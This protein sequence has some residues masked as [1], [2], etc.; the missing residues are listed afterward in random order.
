[1]KVINLFK[2]KTFWGVLLL[3][4][5][6][7]LTEFRTAIEDYDLSLDDILAISIAVIGLALSLL[8]RMDAHGKIAYTPEGLPGRDARVAERL[9]ER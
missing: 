6:V 9:A 2:T 4:V 8:G 3:F 7:V 5:S 1:M